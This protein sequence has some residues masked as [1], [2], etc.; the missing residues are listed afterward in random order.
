MISTRQ[1]SHVHTCMCASA[2]R[3]K[4]NLVEVCTFRS[5]QNDL[6]ALVSCSSWSMRL[7]PNFRL[8]TNSNGV[9]RCRE[10]GLQNLDI[11]IAKIN[12]Q[13]ACVNDRWIWNFNLALQ[14]FGSI[15]TAAVWVKGEKWQILQTK[16]VH[17]CLPSL[18]WKDFDGFRLVLLVKPV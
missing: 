3:T 9:D 7:P 17:F 11:Q 6:H 2:G 12:E 16:R 5:V 8:F 4:S 10:N 14:R 15:V 1:Q 13:C 18:W